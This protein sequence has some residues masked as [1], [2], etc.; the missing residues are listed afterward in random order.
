MAYTV[1]AEK[2]IYPTLNGYRVEI[3]SKSSKHFIYK[4]GFKTLAAAKKF[5][6]TKL[7][8]LYGSIKG[9]LTPEDFGKA[10]DKFKIPGVN[11]DN[12][13]NIVRLSKQANIKNIPDTRPGV[14]GHNRRLYEPPT[15]E[16][17]ERIKA[18]LI[19]APHTT[20]GKMMFEKRKV[21]AEKLLKTGKYSVREAN[22]ILK[23]KFPV[24]K[25][26]GMLS[27]LYDL[28]K[29]IKG[30]PSG[31]EG[32]TATS[33]KKIKK[34][35]FKLNNSEV[36]R[37][38]KGGNKNLLSLIKKTQKILGV[39]DSLATRRIGQLIEAYGGDATYL[40][41]KDDLF[42]RRIRPLTEGLGEVTRIRLFGGIGGGLQRVAAEQKVAKDLGKTRT[43][44]SGLRKRISE[45]LPGL[46]YQ[47]DEI[48]NIRSSA[49]FGTS[50]YSLFVQGIKAD[51][52]QKKAE[53]LDKHTSIYEKKLQNA[54]TLA[55]KKKIAAE[56]N[57]KAKAFATE[58]NKN[59]KSGE[60]PVRTLE[61]SFEQPN[62]VIKNKT[63]L[64]NYGDMFDDIYAKHGYSFKVH[65]DIRTIDQ[66]KPFL[67]GGRGMKQAMKLM[68]A[69]APRIF[70]IP[71][72]AYLGYQM[73]K[74]K[75]VEAAEPE[76][77]LPEVPSVKYNK[78]VGAFLDP[79]TDDK[80]SQAG[81]LTWAVENPIPV[82]AGTAV[83]GLATKKGR[84]IGKGALKKLAALGAP[85]PTAA[86]DAYF[87]N[88][89]IEEGRDP[90][91]IAKDPF[92]WLG[93][94]TMSP[95]TKAAG[96]ADKSGKLASVMRLGMSPGMI[97]GASRF[98]GLPGLALSTGLTAYDQ[99][100]KYKN[101]EGFIYDLFN[102]EEIDNAKISG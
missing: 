91:E 35:L 89:Q 39:N 86:I 15:K 47:T 23:N 100:Q 58:A 55:E 71:V 36:K 63:A 54:K 45:M 80:V 7:K 88:K 75:E 57:S 87:I 48:K 43:F 6:D 5:R 67:E 2:N 90:S 51:I 101:K 8:E 26:S 37:L 102:P 1:P 34:D 25:K 81:L 78:E 29:K 18:N 49:R 82:V 50:P 17:V 28:K 60:P 83:T 19:K 53:A 64:A 13:S 44:F 12:V 59:L 16:I 70:G 99:Y 40:K 97:R 21:E 56:Y 96:L 3:G 61:I 68:R 52:N 22:E 94:A 93:L 69:G 27:I 95:L 72:A 33:V 84:S 14:R 92:N 30:V 85:L 38:M 31:V 24:I 32:E 9:Y 73:L 74:P 46:G 62:N 76:T 10:L 79:Q 65:S 20:Y 98:L 42:L 66:I 77:K 11:P 4:T 41:V